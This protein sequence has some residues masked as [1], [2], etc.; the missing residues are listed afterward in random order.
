MMTGCY[1]ISQGLY[2][3]DRNGI[4]QKNGWKLVDGIWYYAGTTGRLYTGERRIGGKTYWFN[5]NG[6]WIR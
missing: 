5:H 4:L 1:G 3:F 2:L 6:E